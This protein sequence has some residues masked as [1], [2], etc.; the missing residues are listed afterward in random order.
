VNKSYEFY[1]VILTKRG[2]LHDVYVKA[3][4]VAEAL[5]KIIDQ[6]DLEGNVEDY[7]F[8]VRRELSLFPETINN[9]N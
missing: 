7:K 8:C 5:D 2:K 1:F 3:V 4:S 6:L 9:E